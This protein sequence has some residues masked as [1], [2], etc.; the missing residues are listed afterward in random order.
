M[1]VDDGPVIACEEIP[2]RGD[3]SMETLTERIHR[4]EH[5]ILVDAVARLL[6]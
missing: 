6:E 1:G 4:V 5:R 3:D 2:I